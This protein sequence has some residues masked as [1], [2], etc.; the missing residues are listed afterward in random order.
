MF[1]KPFYA[2]LLISMLDLN[3]NN[4]ITICQGNII[5]Y[6]IFLDVTIWYKNN[7]ILIY[8]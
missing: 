5:I 2:L 8:H 7:I 6:P 1:K 4:I 3:I